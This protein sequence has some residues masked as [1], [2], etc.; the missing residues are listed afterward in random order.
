M[1][2]CVVLPHST[3]C[4]LASRSSAKNVPDQKLRLNWSPDLS[5]WC[6]WV[7]IARLQGFLFV[8]SQTASMRRIK[9]LCPSYIPSRLSSGIEHVFSSQRTPSVTCVTCLSAR[10]HTC[11]DVVSSTSQSSSTTLGLP[12]RGEPRSSDECR[13]PHNGH[14]EVAEPLSRSRL[15]CIL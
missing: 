7:W 14:P 8:V 9:D 1:L 5:S 15:A 10:T 12:N 2:E 6:V 13:I 3:C 11:T 4:G